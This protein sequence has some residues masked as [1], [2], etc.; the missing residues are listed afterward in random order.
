MS[1]SESEDPS[2]CKFSFY[3]IRMYRQCLIHNRVLTSGTLI[4]V[5]KIM[6]CTLVSFIERLH[7]FMVISFY[8]SNKLLTLS[9]IRRCNTC[10]VVCV[11]LD[12]QQ[13]CSLVSDM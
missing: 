13:S 9:A 6:I 10:Q 7:L 12:I 3:K 2:F 11:T 1:F 8:Y 5:T 4:I